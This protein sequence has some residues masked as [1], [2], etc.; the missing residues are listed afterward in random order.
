MK[1]KSSATMQDQKSVKDLAD[2]IRSFDD[3]GRIAF[4]T[5]Y[6]SQVSGTTTPLSDVDIA[7]YFQG[8][9]KERFAFRRKALGRLDNAIDLRIFQDLPI[10]IQKEVIASGTPIY[11]GDY[12]TMYE[13]YV[14]TIRKADDFQKYYNVYVEGFEGAPG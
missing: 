9:K 6:G 8:T 4:I 14:K 5:V 12:D 1:D 3:E 2:R 7:V 10:Y 13:T 11:V